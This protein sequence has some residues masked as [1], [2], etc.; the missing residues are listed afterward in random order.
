MTYVVEPRDSDVVRH[1][2]LGVGRGHVL[3]PIE[4][5]GHR[6]S[7]TE[8]DFTDSKVR[9]VL[10]SVSVVERLHDVDERVARGLLGVVVT[11]RISFHNQ[12]QLGEGDSG[13]AEHSHSDEID[14]RVV[15]RVELLVLVEGSDVR[16]EEH[17]DFRSDRSASFSDDVPSFLEVVDGS[18]VG[19]VLLV[20]VD[21]VSESKPDLDAHVGVLLHHFADGDGLLVVVVL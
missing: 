14:S 18:L 8:T 17:L 10:G 13:E 21:F 7:N 16:S 12:Q 19:T 15:I 3:E 11:V 20:V 9:T 6:S 1:L 4:T 2:G 5:V